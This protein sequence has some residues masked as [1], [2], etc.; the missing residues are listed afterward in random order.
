MTSEAIT[1]IFGVND[2]YEQWKNEKD[3]K[4]KKELEKQI[5]NKIKDNLVV[6]KSQGKPVIAVK[7]TDPDTSEISEV[8]LYELKVRTKGIGNS[9][10]MEIS[11]GVL[12]SLSLKNGTADYTKWPDE[13]RSKFAREELKDIKSIINDDDFD[14][15]QNKEELKDRLEKMKQIA[16]EDDK[17]VKKLQ[18]LIDEQEKQNI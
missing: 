5:L 12:G 13:D 9:P 14:Y 1:N 8:P 4:K 16:G 18:A 3:P 11:Q 6:T 7:V 15:E 10:G 2:E 17:N